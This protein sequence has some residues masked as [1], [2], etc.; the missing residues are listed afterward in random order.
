MATLH[1]N[2]GNKAGLPRDAGAGSHLLPLQRSHNVRAKSVEPVCSNAGSNPLRS[3]INHPAT[4]RCLGRVD[5]NLQGIRGWDMLRNGSYSAWF[6]TPRGEGTGI[7][8]LKDGKVTGGDTVLAYS[9]SYVE[10]G[11]A[12]TASI[13]TCRHTQGQPS[14][15]GI[16]IDNVD[17]TLTGNSSATTT[18]SCTGT[19]RQITGLTFEAVLIRISDQPADSPVRGRVGGPKRMP[20]HAQPSIRRI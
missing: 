16:D 2:R 20:N 19:V 10:D 1:R 9:G 8:E 14:V 7:V 3:S 17:L 5:R 12:F 4:Y 18:A 15:F 13:A 11:D 6:R